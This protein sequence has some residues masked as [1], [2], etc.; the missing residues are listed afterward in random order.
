MPI[1]A[2][3]PATSEP[4]SATRGPRGHRGD[5]R[6]AVL[7]ESKPHP[8]RDPLRHEEIQ[9]RREAG[10]A[11]V[12]VIALQFMLA[13]VSRQRHRKL[14]DFVWLIS[15]TR[16]VLLAF[17]GDR[18]HVSAICRTNGADCSRRVAAS[19]SGSNNGARGDPMSVSRLRRYW[20][21]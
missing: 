18:V 16:A 7:Q 17:G 4:S 8:L 15:R 9:S 11:I 12:L 6:E 21:H 2:D 1:L 13:L 3:R 5:H 20:L 10:P 14:W 19:E